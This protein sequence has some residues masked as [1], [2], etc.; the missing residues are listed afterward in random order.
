MTSTPVFTTLATLALV[1]AA[2]S[3]SA[4]PAAWPQQRPIKFV[5][6]NPPGGSNDAT[7]RTVAEA[8]TKPLGQTVIIENK[9]GASGGVAMEAVAAS[10]ADGYTFVVASDSVALQPILRKG[11]KWNVQKDFVPVVMFGTQ[12]IVVATHSGSPYK[13]IQDLV[14][15]AKASPGKI[16]YATSGQGSIQHLAGELLN[17]V[18]GIDLLHIPYKGGGQAVSDLVGG[19]VPAAVLGLAAV[20]PHARAGKVR[21]LAVTSRARATAVPDVPTLDETVAPGY[22]ARQWAGLMAPAGTPPEALARMQ[23]E[24]VAVLATPATRERFDK[25]GFDVS[26]MAG[27]PF[28]DYLDLERARWSKLIADKKLQLD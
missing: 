7:G 3:V 11:L 27:K 16:G 28:V 18:A 17:Q 9:P 15:A 10:P 12:P 8:I 22:D 6:P 19:Q 4:Q 5:V 25:L 21:I 23:R 26:G 24:I 2:S 13:T 1:A 14:A 20:L